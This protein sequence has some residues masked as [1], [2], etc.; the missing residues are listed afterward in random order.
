MNGN[1]SASSR[2]EIGLCIMRES[3]NREGEHFQR[4]TRQT[5]HLRLTFHHCP[6]SECYFTRLRNNVFTHLSTAR[7]SEEKN[8]PFSRRRRLQRERDNGAEREGE[9]AV[10]FPSLSAHPL[11]LSLGISSSVSTDWVGLSECFRSDVW[12]FTSPLCFL[13]P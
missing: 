4:R 1:K 6:T 13:F 2:L 8:N 5:S 7:F 3:S 10:S 9:R 11:P 12:T